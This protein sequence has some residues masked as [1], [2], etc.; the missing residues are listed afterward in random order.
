MQHDYAASRP[1]YEVRKVQASTH[2]PHLEV[3]DQVVAAIEEF[4]APFIGAGLQRA[5]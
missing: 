3:P 5:A 2:F 4:V 1:W